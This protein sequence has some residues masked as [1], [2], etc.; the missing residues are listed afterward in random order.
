MLYFIRLRKQAE[1]NEKKDSRILATTKRRYGKAM[2]IVK[3]E[4]EKDMCFFLVWR[5]VSIQLELKI[6]RIK[7]TSL[8]FSSNGAYGVFYVLIST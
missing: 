2:E 3:G 4:Q 6:R 1:D 8:W 7:K 5:K